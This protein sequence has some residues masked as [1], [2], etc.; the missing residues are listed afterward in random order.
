VIFIVTWRSA[1]EKMYLLE[2]IGMI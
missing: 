2:E 1:A